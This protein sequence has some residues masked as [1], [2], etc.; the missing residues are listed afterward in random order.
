MLVPNGQ[1]ID[2]RP[3]ATNP[4]VE[5]VLN[6]SVR[7]AGQIDDSAGEIDYVAADRAMATLVARGR[8]VKHEERLFTFAYYW[9]EPGEMQ[10]YIEEAWSGFAFLPDRVVQ[11]ARELSPTGQPVQYRVSETIVIADHR[12]RSDL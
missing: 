6:A 11:R 10:A 3:Q 7:V 1:L 5:V 9:R 8:F 2:M 12:K 4:K